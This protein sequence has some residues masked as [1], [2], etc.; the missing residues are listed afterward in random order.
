MFWKSSNTVYLLN[1][2]YAALSFAAFS[3]NTM[4]YIW[5]ENTPKTR[6][7]NAI[8][9]LPYNLYLLITKTWLSFVKN[10]T[11]KSFDF[12]YKKLEGKSLNLA[13]DFTEIRSLETLRPR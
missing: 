13:L 1:P 12:R 3:L 6:Q 2:I 8:K 4:G 5:I 9:K 7:V 11:H 10:G